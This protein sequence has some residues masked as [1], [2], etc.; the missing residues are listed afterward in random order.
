MVEENTDMEVLLE[1]CDTDIGRISQTSK[2]NRIKME[3][4]NN[5]L[6][7]KMSETE[8]EFKAH[9]VINQRTNKL[10]VHIS[11]KQNKLEMEN[12]E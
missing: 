9:D 5:K 8:K 11:T 3:T 12:Q 6:H 1:R 10:L 7:E 4:M 2:H